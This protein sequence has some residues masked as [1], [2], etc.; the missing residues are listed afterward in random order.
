MEENKFGNAAFMRY[1][2]SKL[3]NLLFARQLQKKFDAEGINALAISIHPGE[4]KTGTLF[5][6]QH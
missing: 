5:P 4:V 3:A 1:S 6:F 2:L